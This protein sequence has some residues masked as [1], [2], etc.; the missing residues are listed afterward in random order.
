MIKQFALIFRR[1]FICLP[2]NSKHKI[3]YNLLLDSKLHFFSYLK[4]TSSIYKQIFDIK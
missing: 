2:A 4:K 3:E 1:D